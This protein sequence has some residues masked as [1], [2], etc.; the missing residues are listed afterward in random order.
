MEP[1][2][3]IK[4]LRCVGAARGWKD[5]TV[6]TYAVNDGKFIG[7]LASGKTCTLNTVSDAVRWA[8]ENWPD[9]IEW[10]N[11]VPRP[12]VKALRRAT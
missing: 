1:E 8:S 4:L 2:Q 3:I 7:R 5:S 10:P 6:G 11:E 12:K 9:G